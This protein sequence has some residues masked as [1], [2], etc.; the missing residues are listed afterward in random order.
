MIPNYNIFAADSVKPKTY[1]TM[2][3][4]SLL[5]LLLV[6]TPIFA[7][8][9]ESIVSSRPGQAVVPNTTGKNV[10]QWQTGFNYTDTEDGTIAAARI[11]TYGG[12]IRYGL[13]EKLEIRGDYSLQNFSNVVDGEKVSSVDGFNSLSFG[14]RYNIVSGDGINLGIQADVGLPNIGNISPTDEVAPKFMLIHSNPL[15][16]IFSLTTNWAITWAGDGENEA[17]GIYVIN[18]AFPINDKIGSFIENYGSI[19]DGDLYNYWD[20]GLS[21]LVNDHF[22]LDMGLGYGQNDGLS[23]WFVDAGLSWRVKL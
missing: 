1:L 11:F 23:S 20:T 22:Q 17:T 19:N 18:L 15:G 7:Q 13:L 3:F 12:T 5:T 14:V 9:N 2:K 6:A 8:Y 16:D 4:L 10:L 21:Y